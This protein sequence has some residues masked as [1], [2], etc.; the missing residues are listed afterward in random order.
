[1][2]RNL[3]QI[4]ALSLIFILGACCSNGSVCAE[5]QGVFDANQKSIE[6]KQPCHPLVINGSDIKYNGKMLDFDYVFNEWIKI[7]D[8]GYRT[9]IHTDTSATH[10]W[11]RV[12]F[13][14]LEINNTVGDFSIQIER[15][16]ENF[17]LKTLPDGSA[18]PK[19]PN[20]KPVNEFCGIFTID[21]A[22]VS[23]NST[24]ASIN[25]QKNGKKFL[26]SYLPVKFSLLTAPPNA[27]DIEITTTKEGEFGAIKQV[28]ISKPN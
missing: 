25:R 6:S 14:V 16:S 5:K 15:R 23:K 3:S 11:D 17:E 10:T 9:S 13:S 12:G 26:R 18:A 1:M 7:I 27:L 19:I 8:D 21:G 22:L 28:I 2:P 24:I 20:V 4:I